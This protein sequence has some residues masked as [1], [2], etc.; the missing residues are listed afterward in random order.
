MENN[1]GPSV[2]LPANSFDEWTRLREVIVGRSELYDSHETDSSFRL[3]YFDNVDLP[4]STRRID[5]PS[6]LV[7]ELE[8]DIEEFV[9]T[10]QGAR[11]TVLRPSPMASRCKIVSPLWE[12]RETPPLNVRDQAI[13]LGGTI[14]ETASHQRARYFEN[15]YLKAIFYRYFR[16]G[17]SWISMPR[18]VLGST[19]LDD[20]FFSDKS[21]EID[22]EDAGRICGIEHELI[23][24]GAQ[25]IRFGRDVLVNVANRNHK[26]GFEWLIRHFSGS[27]QFWELKGAADSHID[28]LITPLRPGLLMLRDPQVLAWLPPPL[29]RWDVIYPPEF[30]EDNFPDY[31]TFGFNLASKYIDTNILSIDESTVVVNSLCPELCD[32]LEGRGFDVLRVRHR[33]RRLYNGGFHCF[34]LDTV[35]DGGMESYF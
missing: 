26:L 16:S 9:Q 24:D 11:V 4:A 7:E 22:Y 29:Q 3:F 6:R 13:I 33:H 27:F 17:S 31:S 18:P 34:T 19:S 28:S 5:I 21:M 1:L 10:L 2:Q 15:D 30:S 8:E 20:S 14:L 35:R 32:M 23:F 25:C 12:S